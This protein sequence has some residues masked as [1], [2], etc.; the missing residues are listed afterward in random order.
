[1]ATWVL[2]DI[3]GCASE[4]E[5]LVDELALGPGDRLVSVGDLFHRG[6]DPLGVAR[7][8]ARVGCRWILGNHERVALARFGL[9]PRESD[10]S[11]A[12]RTTEARPQHASELA[13]DGERPL[14]A[15]PADLPELLAFLLTHEG[16]FLEHTDLGAN[17]T[18]DGRAWCLVH[19]GLV[20]GLAPVASTPFELTRI[21]RLDRPGRPAWYDV[22][23][24]P[25]LV[26]FGHTPFDEPRRVEHEGRLVALGLD[27]GCVFGGRL[28]AYSPELERFVSV[29]AERAWARR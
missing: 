5:R 16:Y 2:G 15:A 29:P 7:C 27:T 17:P 13:G 26:L 4:L 19:A 12:E 23:A 28:T 8:L 20:P 9:A 10:A 6:P 14:V 25:T 1:M 21:R 24:G 11:D 18:P 22:Y 3:H